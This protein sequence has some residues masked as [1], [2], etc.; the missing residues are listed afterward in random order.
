MNEATTSLTRAAKRGTLAQVR[1]GDLATYKASL[2]RLNKAGAGVFWTVNHSDGQGRK[3]E[4]ITDVRCLFV[5]LDGTPL[6]PVLDAGVEPHAVVESSPGKWHV[7]WKVAG[8][9]AP[10][11]I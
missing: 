2:A 11:Q 10:I 8:L 3:T 9:S 1:I 5:D 4:N 6:K 7:Y